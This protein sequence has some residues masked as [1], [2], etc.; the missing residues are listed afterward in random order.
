MK[1]I[2]KSKS[3]QKR[4]KIPS[5]VS[6]VLVPKEQKFVVQIPA[7]KLKNAE[8]GLLFFTKQN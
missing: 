8:L 3:V 6:V 1:E 2:K 7:T 4:D 5:L